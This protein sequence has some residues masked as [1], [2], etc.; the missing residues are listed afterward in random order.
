M[1]DQQLLLLQPF[2]DYL[3]FEKR[4]SRHTV[5]SYQDDLVQFLD[6][7]QITFGG[8]EW[9]DV[10]ASIVRS[11]MASQK[12]GGMTSRSIRRK[13]STLRSFFKY[14]VRTGALEIS[15]VTQVTVPKMSK[16]LPGFVQETDMAQLL[17]SIRFSEDWKGYNAKLLFNLFYATGM[18]LSELIQMQPGQVDHSKG[19][20]R[21]LGKGNKERIIPVS[22][23]LIALVK[24]YEQEKKKQFEKADPYLLVTEK[25][26]KMYP[27]Y[28]YLI[29][30]HYLSEIKTLEKKSPHIL[31]HSFA[32]HLTN[33]GASLNAV[34]ELLGHSSLAS[35]QVYTHNTIEKL[36]EVYKKAHPKEQDKH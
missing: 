20:L 34:K 2:L 19:Q 15:P 35:T 27:K 17:E 10:S 32:T 11:W 25:G 29:V 31:R 4:Y 6:F 1:T 18:R 9:K 16:R 14:Q 22:P 8:V 3:K 13:I 33:H 36:K 23:Q 30:N 21:I 12:E 26:K 5:R 24:E 7:L 28:A